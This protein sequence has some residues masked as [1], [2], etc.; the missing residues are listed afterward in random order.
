MTLPFTRRVIERIHAIPRGKVTT[1]G[2]VAAMAGSPRAARQVVRI[3][4]SSSRK[5]GLP[6][7][8][9]IRKDG[10][11]GLPAQRGGDLQRELLEAEGVTFDQRD[12][13]ELKR[14]LWRPQA[15]AAPCNN[16]QPQG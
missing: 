1:Y 13:V 7:H 11:I 4:H 8:R 15:D 12:R 3:L 9:V 10:S 14:W 16:D 6:W 2:A 5:E